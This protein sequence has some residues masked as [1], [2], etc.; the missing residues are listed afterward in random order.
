MNG[1]RPRLD[2][3]DIRAAE[4]AGDWSKGLDGEGNPA[5]S[6]L[7]HA[8]YWKG[9]YTDILE[10]QEKVLNRIR[11]LMALE[12]I[13]I[14]R[15]VELTNVPVVVAQVERFR[16]RLGYWDARIAELDR[17]AFPREQ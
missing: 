7:Q 6:T 15:E 3:P 2:R 8:N 10:M 9:I 17:A 13:E 5:D 1:H 16:Q 14:Q 11:I 12:P 4:R